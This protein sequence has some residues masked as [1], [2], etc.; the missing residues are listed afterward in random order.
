MHTQKKHIIRMFL[1]EHFKVLLKI[2]YWTGLAPFPDLDRKQ[3]QCYPYLIIVLFSSTVNIGFVVTSFHFDSFSMYGNIQRIVNGAFVGSLA[4][5]N[6]VA[7][8]QCYRHKLAY[9]RI[10]YQIMKVESN[11]NMKFST[12]ISFR[13]IVHWYRLKGIVV[14]TIIF[15]SFI[16]YY[17][18]SW[19][20]HDYEVFI[21]V[22]FTVLTQTLS[23]LVLF[24]ILLYVTIVQMFI[25][26]MNKRIK[27]DASVCFYNKSKIEFLKTIKLMHMDVWKLMME[28]NNFFSWH[29]PYVVVHLAIQSTYELYWIFL[30]VQVKLNWLYIFGK[31]TLLTFNRRQAYHHQY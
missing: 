28:V 19:V 2:F 12:N 30:N 10:L 14:G 17:I 4:L 15:I 6:I 23:A 29:L 21:I 25:G 22:C 3:N 16:L 9:D 11:F 24:H 20:E 31:T 5:S 26:E 18:E 27:T 7:N 8:L 13:R 1:L